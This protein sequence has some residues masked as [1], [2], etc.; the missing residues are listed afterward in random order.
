MS[1]LAFSLTVAFALIAAA[2][3]ISQ[4][5]LFNFSGGL[6]VYGTYDDNILLLSDD[7]IAESNVDPEDYILQLHPYLQLLAEGTRTSMILY[8]QYYHE[9]YREEHNLDRT[10]TSF[11]DGYIDLSWEATDR[12]TVSL[13]DLYRDSLYGLERDEVPEIRDDYRFNHFAPKIKYSEEDRFVIQGGFNWLI[14]NYQEAPIISDN[15][16]IGYA[17]WEELGGQ[18]DG[19]ISLNTRTDVTVSTEFWERAYDESLIASYSDSQGYSVNLGLKQKLG[20][21]FNM[22]GYAQYSH[23]EFDDQIAESEDTAYDGFGGSIELENRFKAYSGFTFRAFS[24]FEG[25]ERISGAFYRST[26]LEGEFFTILGK[27]VETAFKFHYSQYSYDNVGEGWKDDFLRAA[28][29]LGYRF[30]HWVS[31]RGQYQY[32]V[33]DSER[34]NDDFDNHLIS[35]Y[36]HFSKDFN[37]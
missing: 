5:A 8:Y 16:E 14:Q 15:G 23:R 22:R 3:I 18:L 20:E 25:S 30:N 21:N 4:A 28:V 11:H 9:W 27:H 37:H 13:Y 24:R 2:P 10:N 32:S 17:D 29:T 12:L 31:V 33:R 36:L 6:D 26:G 7:E 19:E 1:K 35:I 34:P